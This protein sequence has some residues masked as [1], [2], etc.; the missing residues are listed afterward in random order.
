MIDQTNLTI[1]VPVYNE[2][3]TL[4]L[5]L[6]ELIAVCEAKGWK[7]VLVN[8]GSTDG[9]A[10]CLSAYQGVP[11]IKVVNHKVN[12]GYGGALKSGILNSET[13]HVVTIDGDGQHSLADIETVF[14]FSL[15]KDADLVVGSR[16]TGKNTN[17]FREFGK[18]LIRT[19]TRLLMPLPVHDLNSGFKLYRT[20]LAKK[21][22][23]LCPNSMAFSDVITLAFISQR[24][25]VLEHSITIRERQ[26]GKSKI[27]LQTAFE[28]VIEIINIA[29]LFNPLRVFLPISILC[30]LVGFGW[31]IPFILLGRGVSVGAMLAIVVGALFFAIGL[32]ASQL[33]AMRIE[34]IDKNSIVTGHKH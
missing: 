6:P 30:M 31:G 32:I 34:A 15:E 25:L 14:H 16:G 12:R 19:F 11:F 29:L 10:E 9:S 18:W 20:E 23:P 2:A 26:T 28:T 33:S 27:G 1:V 22:L 24:D 17:L 21:Y 5:F 4:P 8:D 3:G 7:A 13:S